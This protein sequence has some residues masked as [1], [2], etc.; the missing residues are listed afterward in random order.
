M[1]NYK[2][3]F[4]IFLLASLIITG[5]VL[6]I[7]FNTIL[8]TNNSIQNIEIELDFNE[9]N[10]Y[11]FVK[12]Q[13]EDIGNRIPGTPEH[14]E[15]INYFIS[16]FQKIDSNVSY[17]FHNFTLDPT[18]INPINC[19]NLLFKLNEGYDNIVILGAHYDSR[20][21]ATKDPINQTAPVPGANDGASGCAV[22][23]EL[24]RVFYNKR[25]NLTC[26][27]WFLFFDAEDQGRDISW[28]IPGWGWCEG[29]NRFVDNIDNFYNSSSEYFE[30]MIL[31]DMVG[32]TNLRFINEQYSTS[33]LLNEL[34]QVGRQ[35]GYT[36]AFPSSPVSQ[37]IIDDHQPF[38]EYGIPSADLI[39]NFWS[40]SNWPYHHTTSDDL[41]HISNTS[42]MITGR[43][44][45]QFIYNIFF[46]SSE[47]N[48]Q[49]NYPWNLDTVFID[50][51]LYFQ[52]GIIFIFIVC[53]IIIFVMKYLP[54]QTKT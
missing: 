23:L 6:I 4:N 31:L 34:F 16:E 2:K 33:T 54:S 12:N 18:Y 51:N 37:P 44:V 36:T 14:Q 46:N 40:D 30:C 11:I 3:S 25:I 9:E 19:S 47:Y 22:L 24:A 38:V 7:I 15:S 13:T 27:I 50:Y 53:P 8:L 32:G 43:T 29:S 28:S 49:G 39:I 5:V 17:Y 48:Y 52:I 10:A 26:E 42:L 1:N 45:E 35:L 20:A 21:R 41:S